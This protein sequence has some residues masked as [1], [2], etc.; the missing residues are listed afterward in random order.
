MPRRGLSAQ[1]RRLGI[2][3][4]GAQH[5]AR[6][7]SCKCS[8]E[9]RG[10]RPCIASPTLRARGR[11]FHRYA[12]PSLPS[13]P[14]PYS[15][16]RS[17]RSRGLSPRPP[18]RPRL[19]G[20]PQVPSPRAHRRPSLPL[21]EYLGV[22]PIEVV[23]RWG[24]HRNRVEVGPRPLHRL[25]SPAP[26]RA[27]PPRGS[28]AHTGDRW[29]WSDCKRIPYW[30]DWR[31]TCCAGRVVWFLGGPESW[32]ETPLSVSLRQCK[33]EMKG[34]RGNG[35]ISYLCPLARSP[36]SVGHRPRPERM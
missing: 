18:G 9:M 20:N 21:V 31:L 36:Y 35:S 11:E 2:A 24:P 3:Q 7:C 12:P 19:L 4:A 8:G 26:R 25:R 15:R 6:G 1:L 23:D 16:S 28:T 29:L 30:I 5:I 10:D 13:A 17:R 32:T 33:P 34:N 14:R 22:V 27:S